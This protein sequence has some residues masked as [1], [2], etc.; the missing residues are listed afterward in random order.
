[1]M[2][3]STMSI[4]RL[5]WFWPT[6]RII[7]VICGNNVYLCVPCF[8]RVLF[9]SYLEENQILVSNRWNSVIGNLEISVNVRVK[10]VTCRKQST[11]GSNRWRGQTLVKKKKTSTYWTTLNL[12]KQCRS[13]VQSWIYTL[14]H[15]NCDLCQTF[16]VKSTCWSA[17]ETFW[18]PAKRT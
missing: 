10:W 3:Q 14:N 13:A 11:C 18:R 12:W 15:V 2:E 7:N 6:S 1:M 4:Y 16:C 5:E 8:P 9:Q 17:F